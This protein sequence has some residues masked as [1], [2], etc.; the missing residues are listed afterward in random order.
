M[1]F[2][3]KDETDTGRFTKIL[4]LSWE[5][6]RHG[7]KVEQDHLADVQTATSSSF[8]RRFAVSEELQKHIW[9]KGTNLRKIRRGICIVEELTN[10]GLL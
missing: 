9:Y 10:Y 6:W 4:D 2:K 5:A 7:Q 8:R 1:S 3:K